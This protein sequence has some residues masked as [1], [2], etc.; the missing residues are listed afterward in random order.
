MYDAAPAFRPA[1]NST[2]NAHLKADATMQSIPSSHRL[3]S[4]RTKYNVPGAA[5][6][7]R[8]FAIREFL[9]VLLRL[10]VHSSP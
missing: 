6:A 8:D 4:S 9:H 7:M 1:S 2:Q 10:V 3:F 5:Q